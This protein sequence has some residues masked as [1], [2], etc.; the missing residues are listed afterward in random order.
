MLFSVILVLFRTRESLKPMLDYS[1]A[2]PDLP[3]TGH[4]NINLYVGLF[5]YSSSS[6]YYRALEYYMLG[7]SHARP[8]LHTAGRRNI[9]RWIIPT[10]VLIS[11]NCKALKYRML[12]Y[13]NVRPELQT[14]VIGI[15]T[16]WIIPMFA[17]NRILQ[18]VGKF[19]R[20]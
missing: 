20:Q 14:T 16:L 5:Q 10:L 13:S 3:T 15:F 12:G 8:D 7:Y 4:W 18:G 1:N 2:R 11:E 17:L 9:R 6:A 19:R